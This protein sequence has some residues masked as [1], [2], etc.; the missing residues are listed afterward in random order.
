MLSSN[1][2]N[3]TKQKQSSVQGVDTKRIL[4]VRQVTKNL[5]LSGAI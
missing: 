1:N 5:T 2:E 3:N 4:E